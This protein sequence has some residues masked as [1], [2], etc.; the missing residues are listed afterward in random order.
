MRHRIVALGGTL[1]VGRSPEGGTEVRAMVPH[2]IDAMRA[3]P[4]RAPAPRVTRRLS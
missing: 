2:G 1:T 3:Q 4:T